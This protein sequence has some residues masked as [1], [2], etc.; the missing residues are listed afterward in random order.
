MTAPALPVSTEQR[1]ELTR[2]AKSTALAHRK[3][4]QAKALLWASQGLANQEI[5]RRCEVDSDTV[6]RWRVRFASK[7]WRQLGGR[8]EIKMTAGDELP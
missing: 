4:V 2:M 7:K 6:R 1:V 8:P 3:V 5:A